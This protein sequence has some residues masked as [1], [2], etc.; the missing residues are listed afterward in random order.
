MVVYIPVTPVMVPDKASF[1]DEAGPEEIRWRVHPL[2]ENAWKS[3]LL[4]LIIA[5]TGIGAYQ[6]TGW[7]GMGAIAVV[8]LVVSMAPYIFPTNY[9]MDVDGIEITF[10]GVKRFREWTEF[11]NFLPHKDGVH[12]STFKRPNAMEAFRG[13]YIRFKPGNREEV[14]RFLEKH[15]KKGQ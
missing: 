12:L 9:L 7:P 13:S 11:R 14:L 4:W 15:I 1:T 6:W 5:A 8:L 2:T 3:L 10:I